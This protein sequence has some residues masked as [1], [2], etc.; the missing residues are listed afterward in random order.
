MQTYS[1]QITAHETSRA[2]ALASMTDLMTNAGN[3]SLTLTPEQTKT[4]DEPRRG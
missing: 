3:D 2:A 4:Y 1:E